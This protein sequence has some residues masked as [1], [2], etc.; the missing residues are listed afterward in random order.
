VQV[1]GVGLGLGLGVGVGVGVGVGLDEGVGLGIGVGVGVG[2]GALVPTVTEMDCLKTVP[3]L[4][5]AWT[6]SRC[7]P[8]DMGMEAFR[9]PPVCVTT[10]VPST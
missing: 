10:G 2:G 9:D 5:L 8:V 4:S 6:V 3:I 7:V 1:P